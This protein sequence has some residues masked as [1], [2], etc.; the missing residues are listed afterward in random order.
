LTGLVDP[1]DRIQ[2]QI[3]AQVVTMFIVGG[4]DEN[5]SFETQTRME[6]GVN[7]PGR[8]EVRKC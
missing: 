5:T 2:T 7:H 6:I 4:I 3:A 1:D 8:R